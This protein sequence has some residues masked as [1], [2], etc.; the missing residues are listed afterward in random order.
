MPSLDL[1]RRRRRPTLPR[2]SV[3]FRAFPRGG[4]AYEESLAFAIVRDRDGGGCNEKFDDAEDRDRNGDRGSAA[5]SVIRCGGGPNDSAADA[6]VRGGGGL[7]EF[8]T[9]VSFRSVEPTG[10]RIP[11]ISCPPPI[12]D[13][14][15]RRCGRTVAVAIL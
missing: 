5:N 4:S 8:A 7:K 10:R 15:T 9:K 1:K 12:R 11:G 14:A 6:V 13:N 3:W 2:V